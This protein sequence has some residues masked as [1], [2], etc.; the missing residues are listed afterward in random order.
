M[1]MAHINQLCISIK[2]SL[3]SKEQQKEFYCHEWVSVL[4]FLTLSNVC[5][6]S[7]PAWSL[8]AVK[9]MLSASFCWTIYPVH[10]GNCLHGEDKN[11]Q[12]RWK[13]QMSYWAHWV[14]FLSLEMAQNLPT[15]IGISMSY[16]T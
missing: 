16:M 15:D 9:T 10:A 8:C 14:I 4:V 2:K 6:K 1:E 11:L 5:M 7:H 12:L 13:G 3:V